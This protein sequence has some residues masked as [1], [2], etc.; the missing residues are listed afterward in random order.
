MSS[1]LKGEQ[2]TSYVDEVA[3]LIVEYEKILNKRNA[4]QNRKVSFNNN[5]DAQISAL[6]I[7]L[8]EI[9]NQIIESINEET[10][11]WGGPDPAIGGYSYSDLTGETPPERPV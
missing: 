3:D 5:I 7:E 6:Q 10:S 11:E 2:V 4:K 9:E 1:I 8:D